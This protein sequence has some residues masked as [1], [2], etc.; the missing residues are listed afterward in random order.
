MQAKLQHDS[1]AVVAAA[2]KAAL[3]LLATESYNAATASVTELLTKTT[4]EEAHRIVSSWRDL[5]P[6]LITKYVLQLTLCDQ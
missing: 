4:V 2:D 5:L 1:F 6:K 3:A